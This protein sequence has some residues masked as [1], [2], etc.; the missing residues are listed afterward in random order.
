MY[1]AFN[2]AA[3]ENSVGAYAPAGTTVSLRTA[4]TEATV[5][6][7]V[8]FCTSSLPFPTSSMET[9][10]LL[11][12]KLQADVLPLVTSLIF[13]MQSLRGWCLVISCLH[14]SSG[15]CGPVAAFSIS[16]NGISNFQAP[17]PNF[18]ACDHNK[19]ACRERI[20]SRESNTD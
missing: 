11:L 7:H 6:G 18:N 3:K 8:Y 12:L 2:V 5:V 9:K 17:T 20:S 16:Q 15:F 19:C 14:K 4:F 13:R 10:V 1:T